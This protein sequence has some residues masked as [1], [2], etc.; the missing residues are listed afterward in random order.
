MINVDSLLS[1]LAN[2]FLGNAKCWRGK[3][4]QKS[5]QSDL[6][7][8]LSLIILH[9]EFSEACGFGAIQSKISAGILL[10]I[11]KLIF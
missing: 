9:F 11:Y 6:V 8:L 5:S 1:S 10:D 4:S 7:P 3:V 2:F